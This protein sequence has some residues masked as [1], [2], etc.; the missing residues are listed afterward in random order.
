MNV[1]YTFRKYGDVLEEILRTLIEK[2]KGLECNT[3]GL[4]VGLGAPNPSLE[5]LKRYREMGG[6]IL[7]I[8]SDSHFPEYL[9]YGFDRVGDMLKSCGFQYYTVFVNRKPEFLPL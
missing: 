2:G 6:E 3:N 4:R 1:F 8:G 9:G 5:I 7:T